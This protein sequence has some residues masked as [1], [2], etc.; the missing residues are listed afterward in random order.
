MKKIFLFLAIF[1]CGASIKAQ[2]F[3]KIT[4]QVIVQDS[5][6][7]YY[8]AWGDYDNDGDLDLFLP[9]W[10]ASPVNPLAK[11]FMYQNNCNGSFTRIKAIPGGLVTDVGPQNGA[12]WIDY[13]NDGNL[14]L[15]TWSGNYFWAYGKN[16]MYK[17]NG[18]GSFSKPGLVLDTMNSI[19]AAWADYNN[20][21]ILDVFL[22]KAL[23]KGN[24]VDFT[25]IRDSTLASYPFN[26]DAIA[27]ADY[28]N[29]GYMDLYILDC[30]ANN[31]NYLYHNNG[32]G[33]FTRIMNG[34][35]SGNE[36]TFGCA[37]GDYDNDGFLD[38][39]VANSYGHDFL[40]HNN[41]NGTFTSITTGPI[42]N[43]PVYVNQAGAAWCDYDNDGDLDLFVPTFY[44]NFLYDNNGDG[45]FTQ[46]TTEIVTH[47][48]PAE[49]YGACWADYNNDGA[50]DLFV[51]TGW[52]NADDFLYKNI[53]YENSGNT[54]HWLKFE[55]VGVTSNRDAIGARVYA[56]ATINGHTVWQMREI[57]AN[58]TRGGESGGTS[59]VVH[60]GFGNATVIDSLKIVWP[61]SHT[62]QIFTNVPANQFLKI[63]EGINILA[64]V[65][66]CKPD[67]LPDN[68]AII[69][70]KIYSDEN[71]NC[72]FDNTDFPIV[73]RMVQATPGPYFTLTD[74]DGNYEFKLDTGNYV[75]TQATVQNDNWA[76]QTCQT[77]SSYNVSIGVRDT[78][79]AKDF[80]LVSNSKSP[81]PGANINLYITSEGLSSDNCP[82]PSILTGPCPGY[83]HQ[84]CFTIANSGS[85]PTPPNTVLQLTF[86]SGFNTVSSTST[87]LTTPGVFGNNTITVTINDPINPG[88]PLP[89]GS[90]EVCVIVH[91]ALSVIC[92]PIGP[93]F[94]IT[95]TYSNTGITTNLIAN[96]DF[97]AGNTGF[98][99]AYTPNCLVPPFYGSYC[100]GNSAGAV[101]PCCWVQ[102]GNPGMFLIADGSTVGGTDVWETTLPISVSTNTE[103]VF[104]A[105]FN[106]IVDP[107]QDFS[108]PIMRVLINNT[109]IITTPA[110]PEIPDNWLNYN[111]HWC[112]LNSTSANIEIRSITNQGMGNDFGIDN[113]QFYES[114]A[115]KTLIENT[116]CPCDPNDKM[117]GPKGCGPQGNIAKD[118]TLTYKIRFENIGTGAAHNIIL[119]DPLDADIDITTLQ[120]LSS[121]HLITHIEII[122]DN[123]LIISFEGINLPGI[124]DSLNNKGFVVFSISPKSNTPDGSAITNQAGIYFDANDVVLTNTTLNTVRDNPSPDAAFQSKHSCTNTGIVYDFTYTG[125]TPDNATFAWSF[126]DG[127]PSTSTQQNPSGI[128]FNSIGTKQISLTVTRYGC[129]QM[130]SDSIIVNSPLSDN[131]KKV[132]ICHKGHT[133]T[134]SI[135]ALPAHLA[136]GDCVGPCN[137]NNNRIAEQNEQNE[138]GSYDFNII[139]NPSDGKFTLLIT[140]NSDDNISAYLENEKTEICIYDIFGKIIYKS[141]VVN[142]NSIIDL[143]DH[144]KGLYFYKI[145]SETKFISTG[146]LIIQ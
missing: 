116:C 93:P 1:F 89:G 125:N 42:V 21:G 64:N 44:Q 48:T 60:I 59:H 46:N 13:N 143:S 111:Y 141:Q 92:P 67:L 30:G 91:V 18:D 23:Y 69:K 35:G 39:W 15:F 83:D 5:V 112:S 43:A 86:P 144:S 25:L 96:G 114:S 94:V 134:V 71:N 110:I 70:G 131:G 19:S 27:W 119:R 101:N 95:A 145:S 56:K 3:S 124:Q 105:D 109:T 41:G 28:D 128:I 63:T 107:L 6:N 122:P 140:G 31:E 75:I 146:K 108:D 78:V 24:G 51:N 97:T 133:I 47:D 80:S 57:N 53:L 58:S 37:W 76:L 33:T 20:D 40:Y 50:M 135:N 90:C 45:T 54:N 7:S 74:K 138:E 85:N 2:V 118:E 84:Y 82:P 121:S 22:D 139:P 98:T 132:T 77:N 65:E 87:C 11:N 130:V 62:T 129:S 103:Y 127:T 113:I 136:H 117:V 10:F 8:A 102:T 142:S 61:A 126:A 137:N 49:S 17:N 26:P 34:P 120:I 29:D 115:K 16:I 12:Y 100:V 38:L 9:M 36:V 73:N 66:A 123:T 99:S 14:D 32:D 88:W 79:L 55:C 4:N 68:P 72:V 81:C 104:S 106:N 52:A